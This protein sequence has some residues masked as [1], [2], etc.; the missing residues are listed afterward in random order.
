MQKTRQMK[1]YRKKYS[2]FL[3][4]FLIFTVFF[5]F[6][7]LI[8]AEEIIHK[9]TL[10][11]GSVLYGTLKSFSND[12]YVF[13]VDALGEIKVSLAD[14]ISIENP[15]GV[16]SEIP[17]QKKSPLKTLYKTIRL[18][19]QYSSMLPSRLIVVVIA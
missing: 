10:K 13:Q 19:F 15:S 17:G 7:S 8:S 1:H 18:W 6:S 9:I 4:L 3:E 16:Q 14:V 12:T 2:F 11:D 5:F